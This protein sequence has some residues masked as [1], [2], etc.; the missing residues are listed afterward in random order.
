MSGFIDKG[1][2]IELAKDGDRNRVRQR[3]PKLNLDEFMIE[4]HY[5][6][7]GKGYRSDGDRVDGDSP[8]NQHGLISGPQYIQ[9]WDTRP[10]LDG[11]ST[12][13]R[14]VNS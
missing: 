14:S 12:I 13:D 6:P 7:W 11:I 3:Y 9:H 2:V 10:D 8:K 5:M 1:W 4:H